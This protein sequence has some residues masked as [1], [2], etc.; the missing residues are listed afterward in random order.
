MGCSARRQVGRWPRPTGIART[1]RCLWP[2]AL[3]AEPLLRRGSFS[4]SGGG[5][6]LRRAG[7]ND[8]DGKKTPDELVTGNAFL[9]KM[10]R[11]GGYGREGERVRTVGGGSTV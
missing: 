4:M 7:T 9:R 5:C 8:A 10:L 1:G 3:G 11:T 6:C 2:K